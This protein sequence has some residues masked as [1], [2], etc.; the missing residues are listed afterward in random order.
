MLRR[1]LPKQQHSKPTGSGLFSASYAPAT[2]CVAYPRP[3]DTRV[4]TRVY[5]EPLDGRS[6]CFS[7]SGSNRLYKIAVADA[8]HYRQAGHRVISYGTGSAMR[9]PGPSIDKPNVYAFGTPYDAIYEDLNSK[10]SRLC[11]FILSAVAPC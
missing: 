11:V 10:D 3:L 6:P 1:R 7:V 5:S 4:L 8:S 9:L 2:M